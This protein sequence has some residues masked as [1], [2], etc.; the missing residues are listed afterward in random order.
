MAK[1]LIS[2]TL[3]G[4]VVYSDTTPMTVI[5]STKAVEAVS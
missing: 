3:S 2:S 5:N 4:K 1:W